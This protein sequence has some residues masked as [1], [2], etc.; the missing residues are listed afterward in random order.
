MQLTRKVYLNN[1][2]WFLFI[3][4]EEKENHNVELLYIMLFSL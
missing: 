4:L 2:R 3:L 1:E